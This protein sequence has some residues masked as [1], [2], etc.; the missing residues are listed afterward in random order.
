MLLTL[1]NVKKT[2]WNGKEQSTILKNINLQINKGEFIAIKGRSGSGKTTLLNIIAGLAKCDKGH[3]VF[4][5]REITHLSLND[6]LKYRRKNIGIVTQQFNLLNDRNVFENIAL[7]LNYEKTSK[8]E[9]VEKVKHILSTLK[10]EDYLYKEIRNLSGGEK[11]RIAIARAMIKEPS[12]IIADEPTGSLDVETE[13][14]I[15]EIFNV[16]KDNGVTFII[17]TH[18]DNVANI[19]DTVYELVSGELKCLTSKSS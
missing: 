18:D 15:L 1:S 14:D 6:Q 11:Q 17:V 16:L 12:L 13:K 19:C 10:M 5:D 4:N 8:K 7:P 9:K 2:F 3:I